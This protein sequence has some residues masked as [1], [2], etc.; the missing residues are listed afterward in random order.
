M[1][2]GI[3][4]PGRTGL[5]KSLLF[6]VVECYHTVL[7]KDYASWTIWGKALISW[8]RKYKGSICYS[9]IFFR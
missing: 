5:K 4:K 2:D 7:D 1:P 6:A 8:A 9:Y 3:E